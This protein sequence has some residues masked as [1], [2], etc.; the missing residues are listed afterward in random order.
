MIAVAES[1]DILQIELEVF[2]GNDRAIALYRKMGFE[3]VSHV[4]N[5][6]RMSDGSFLKEYLMIR[7]MR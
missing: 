6:I 2:E 4:P 3:I 7:P 1:W 5:A